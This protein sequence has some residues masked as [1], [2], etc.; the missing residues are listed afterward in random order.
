M[1]HSSSRPAARSAVRAGWRSRAGRGARDPPPRALVPV[2]AGSPWSRRR[3][4]PPRRV[5]QGQVGEHGDRRH[6]DDRRPTSSALR[7]PPGGVMRRRLRLACSSLVHG[8]QSDA[9]AAFARR[10]RRAVIARQPV[11][12]ATAATAPRRASARQGAGVG[13]A[14]DA[15]GRAADEARRRCPSGAAAS[16]RADLRAVP[17]RQVHEQARARRPRRRSRGDGRW[18]MR[19]GTTRA[20]GDMSTVASNSSAPPCDGDRHE[21]DTATGG[22]AGR[23]CRRL[24]GPPRPACGRAGR[25]P[26]CRRSARRRRSRR[27]RDHPGQHLR[28][29]P[30]P[31]PS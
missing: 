4:A 19:P 15:V 16:S 18:S 31:P 12:A 3:A 20:A 1:S 11:S 13:A 2:R 29:H 17:E 8:L 6:R 23:P 7:Q 26:S 27:A 10:R 30:S 28:G 9:P 22:G 25:P 14:Q 5:E 21:R 24:A